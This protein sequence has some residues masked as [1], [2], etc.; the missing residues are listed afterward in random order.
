MRQFSRWFMALALVLVMAGVSDAQQR[1]ARQRGGPGFQGRPGAG[2]QRGGFP[3]G[4]GVT[5][6]QLLQMEVVQA[7][8]KLSDEQIQKIQA[9]G[10][11]ME[12]RFRQMMQSVRGGGQGGFQEMMEAREKLENQVQQ[13]MGR[14]LDKDQR[15]R[16]NEIYYQALGARAFIDEQVIEKLEISK[17]QQE[18]IGGVLESAGEELR[19]KMQEMFAGRGR[20]PGQGGQPEGDRPNPGQG[21]GARGEG[22]G[23]FE[24]MAT[25]MEE[26]QK[27]T[28]EKVL[29]V[30]TD[31]QKETWATVTGERIELPSMARGFGGG[32]GPGG[33][34]RPPRP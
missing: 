24:A 34:G 18:E 4:P 25:Q 13:A 21:R 23:G 1:G 3:G 11:Q 12:G 8:L 9:I 30:L 31:E 20:G 15:T 10:E 5:I 29:A 19:S 2:F 32:R 6:P 7:D 27:A 17:A 22:R 14:L 33:G 28:M 26:F 16:A